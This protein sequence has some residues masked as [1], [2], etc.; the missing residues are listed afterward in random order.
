METLPA[1]TTVWLTA[2]IAFHLPLAMGC[3]HKLSPLQQKA[4]S[5][6]V[7]STP[8]P[9]LQAPAVSLPTTLPPQYTASSNI[10]TSAHPIMAQQT[11][12][13]TGLLHPSNIKFQGQNQGKYGIY[14]A[15]GQI[16][17]QELGLGGV[18]F[19]GP[20]QLIGPGSPAMMNLQRGR[21]RG[22]SQS[23]LGTADSG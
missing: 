19:P 2:H 3:Y 23:G 13:I 20:P 22:L 15:G 5:Q 21:K 1:Y 10:L 12:L 17:G 18:N 14:E 16:Q 4:Q 11:P 8:Y 9:L 6:Q 7:V